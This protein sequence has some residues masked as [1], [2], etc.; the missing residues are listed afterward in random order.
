MNFDTSHLPLRTPAPQASAAT[1]ALRAAAHTAS[2]L[3]RQAPPPRATRTLTVARGEALTLDG[4]SDV[5]ARRPIAESCQPF[6]PFLLVTTI[7]FFY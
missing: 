4:W 5:L 7:L 3:G 2:P 1:R 6:S